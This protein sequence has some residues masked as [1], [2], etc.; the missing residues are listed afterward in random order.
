MLERVRAKEAVKT[1]EAITRN[2]AEEKR[3]SMLKR[4]P[5][6]MRIVRAQFV[7]EKRP[8]LTMDSVVQKVLDS[9]KSCIAPGKAFYPLF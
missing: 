3:T 4:L 8:A 5:G 9:Y 2:P 7:T 1:A 6:I